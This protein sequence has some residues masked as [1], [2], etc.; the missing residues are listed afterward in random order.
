MVDLTEITENWLAGVRVED[1]G[2]NYIPKYHLRMIFIKENEE[3]VTIEYAINT[4]V[5][6]AAT[7]GMLLTGHGWRDDKVIR[8]R[9]IDYR[10]HRGG[11]LAIVEYTLDNDVSV[12]EINIIAGNIHKLATF[13]EFI[14]SANKEKVVE[15]YREMITSSTLNDDKKRY[16]IKV[17]EQYYNDFILYDK[18]SPIVLSHTFPAEM[19]NDEAFRRTIVP[20]LRSIESEIGQ[21]IEKCKAQSDISN[22][23]SFDKIIFDVFFSGEPGTNATGDEDY[24][25]TIDNWFTKLYSTPVKDSIVKISVLINGPEYL[26]NEV[27]NLLDNA[28]KTYDLELGFEKH[29]LEGGLVC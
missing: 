27:W 20:K 28:V 5:E 29:K 7:L 9:I 13:D 1:D 6:Y 15:E 25:D 24:F 16:W 23:P 14:T 21:F 17:F 10:R 2:D 12:E 26:I 11:Y 3:E 8:N 18:N 4:S 22:K 19:L